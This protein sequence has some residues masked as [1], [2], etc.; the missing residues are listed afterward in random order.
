M[1]AILGQRCYETDSL[2]YLCL[3]YC[4]NYTIGMLFTGFLFFNKINIDINL[5]FPRL[6]TLGAEHLGLPNDSTNLYVH[7]CLSDYQKDISNP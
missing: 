5:G 7:I 4:T 2:D 3:C 1:H 6:I